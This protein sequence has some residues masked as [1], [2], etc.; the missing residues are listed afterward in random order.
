[1]T[2]VERKV[3]EEIVNALHDMAPEAHLYGSTVGWEDCEEDVRTVYTLAIKQLMDAG[4]IE[5]GPHLLHPET[6]RGPRLTD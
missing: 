5:I 4:K 1:M 3:A 2:S 6:T